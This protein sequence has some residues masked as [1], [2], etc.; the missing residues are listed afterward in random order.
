MQDG[1]QWRS[2]LPGARDAFTH[3]VSPRRGGTL[4]GRGFN[5]GRGPGGTCSGP[6]LL[7]VASARPGLKP[8]TGARRNLFRTGLAPGRVR[9][10]GVETPAYKGAAPPGAWV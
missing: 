3:L 4:V 1:C 6:A 5:P 7:R 10:S 9:S 8:R 2:C